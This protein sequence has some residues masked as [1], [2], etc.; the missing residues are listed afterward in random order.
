MSRERDLGFD[1]DEEAEYADYWFGE[2]ADGAANEDDYSEDS[3]A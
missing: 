3:E 2:G 1:V